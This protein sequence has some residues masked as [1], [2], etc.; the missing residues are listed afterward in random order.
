[1]YDQLRMEEIM[2]NFRMK[3]IRERYATYLLENTLDLDI[4]YSLAWD[5]L[6]D[7]LCKMHPSEL[8]DDMDYFQAPGGP[9]DDEE[10]IELKTELEEIIK[11]K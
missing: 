9:A 1:M 5:T 7:Q 3:H 4:I 2:P 11:E 8:L 6:Y 10:L